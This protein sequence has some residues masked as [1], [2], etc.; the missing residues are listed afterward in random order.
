MIKSVVSLAEGD[1]ALN[2]SEIIITVNQ[3]GPLVV[4]LLRF[5][6]NP[7]LFCLNFVR[8]EFRWSLFPNENHF[9][10]QT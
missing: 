10:I 2:R 6:A 4:V 5:Q 9:Y 7:R 8:F 3:V 1:R